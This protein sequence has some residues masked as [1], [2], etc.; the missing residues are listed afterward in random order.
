MP[1]ME[2]RIREW[3]RSLAVAFGG[4]GEVVEELESH[5]REEIDRLTQAGQA[6]DA[7]LMTA[8]AKLGAPENLAAE[9][10]RAVPPARWLPIPVGLA[11]IVLLFGYWAHSWTRSKQAA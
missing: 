4:Y 8:Q 11:L 9:Y 10:A 7:A 3:K 2:T 1:D 5:L 6:P